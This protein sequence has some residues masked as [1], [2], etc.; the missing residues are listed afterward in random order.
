M[1]DHPC[2]N[3][4]LRNGPRLAEF[5]ALAENYLYIGLALV[6]CASPEKVFGA[7]RMIVMRQFEC[8]AARWN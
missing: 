1:R 2:Q 7:N 4:I 3:V 6:Q 5:F 8:F